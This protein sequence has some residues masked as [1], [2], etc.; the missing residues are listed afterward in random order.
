M[1]IS[2]LIR[3]LVKDLF[4]NVEKKAEKKLSEHYT[5][6]V[7]KTLPTTFEEFT[8]LPQAALKDPAD[9]AAMTVVAFYCY[10]SNKEE[11]LKMV[12]YLRGPRP[13]SEYDKQFYADRFSDNPNVPRSYFKGATPDNDYTPSE[14]FTVRPFTN[15]HSD[16]G[17]NK[18]R[19]WI[20][21][22]GAESPRYVD[23]RLAKDKK[24]Y[25]W[26][27]YILVDVRQMESSNPWA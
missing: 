27:Q 8:Q 11:G 13:I 21:S 15:P 23:V 22:G 6:V 4:K 9:T 25:L 26:E 14:P 17:T 5:D 1:A 24:W 10:A 2:T 20:N 12:N 3:T 7:F 16:L 19:M 18:K